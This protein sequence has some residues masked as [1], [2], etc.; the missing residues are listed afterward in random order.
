MP[1]RHRR[2]LFL[3][4]TLVTTACGQQKPLTRDTAQKLLA[5]Y[6]F[7]TVR[8][9]FPSTPGFVEFSGDQ[10]TSAGLQELIQKQI[11]VCVSA[12][13]CK[14]GERGAG[15]TQSQGGFTY[16]A[17]TYI[18]AEI[19]GIT[20]PSPN[21]AIVQVQ[22]NFKPTDLYSNNKGSF[23]MAQHGRIVAG[24]QAEK[25]LYD[26]AKPQLKEIQFQLFDDGWR[27]K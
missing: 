26:M 4:V 25:S 9:Q 19:R 13:S 10:Q 24:M 27:I 2:L 12:D 3:A 14:P 7:G 5:K 21:L 23:D 6:N 20:Q 15:L 1:I 17:G 22:V 8:G 16:T 11:I 18:F